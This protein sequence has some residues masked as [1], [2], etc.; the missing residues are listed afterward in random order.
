M[1]QN[2]KRIKA[3][4]EKAGHINP[5]VWWAPPDGWHFVSGEAPPSVLG[6]NVDAA[7]QTVK[8]RYVLVPVEIKTGRRKGVA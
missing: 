2:Q 7:I 8:R 3:A 4:L 5:V 6:S 1:N